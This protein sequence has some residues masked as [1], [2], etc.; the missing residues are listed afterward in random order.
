M[1]LLKP[2][3]HVMK[4]VAVFMYG[5]NVRLSDAVACYNACNGRHHSSV[6]TVLR[7]CF[8]MWDTDEFQ[9]HKEQYYSMLLKCLNWI[10][11]KAR[12]QYEVV[13]PV[14]ILSKYGPAA[15]C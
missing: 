15:T 12:D 11:W 5:N 1:F 7:A 10:N 8:V 2:N 9:S 6:E 3:S 13:K 4:K 14:V